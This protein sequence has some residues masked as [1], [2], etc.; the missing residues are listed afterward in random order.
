MAIIPDSPADKAKRYGGWVT[1]DERDAAVAA[2]REAC[3]QVI[4]QL[5]DQMPKKTTAAERLTAIAVLKGAAIA[6]RAR[7]SQPDPKEQE[8]QD[9]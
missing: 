2:E 8:P 7:A 6:I 1:V 4:D 3:A 9:D 5:V